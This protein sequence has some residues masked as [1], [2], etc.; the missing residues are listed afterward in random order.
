MQQR[1]L[2]PHPLPSTPTLSN[3]AG[4]LS[5]T[6]LVTEIDQLVEKRLH[7]SNLG[8]PSPSRVTAYSKRLVQQCT[9]AYAAP[10]MGN[11]ADLRKV[12]VWAL[13]CIAYE[14]CS[15]GERVFSTNEM[16]KW[17]QVRCQGLDGWEVKG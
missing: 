15:G 12:D 13:G 6:P 4:L 3:R 1:I 8:L 7:D 10:E 17:I 11:G 14:L 2:C 5:A 16:Q 9:A